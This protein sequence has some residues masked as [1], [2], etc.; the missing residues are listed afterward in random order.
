MTG[1]VTS[2]ARRNQGPERTQMSILFRPQIRPQK[3]AL[4]R[5]AFVTATAAT[6]LLMPAAGFSQSPTTG[7]A[8]R[9]DAAMEACKALGPTKAGVDCM[10]QKM[11]QQ[12]GDAR[13]RAAAAAA[14]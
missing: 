11:D 6:V 13:A 2:F 5:V 1:E 12:I 14:L 7:A 8:P 10:V 3:S 4:R 9:G